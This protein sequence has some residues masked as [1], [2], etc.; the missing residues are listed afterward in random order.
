M[1]IILPASGHPIIHIHFVERAFHG[2]GEAVKIYGEMRVA[3]ME[4]VWARDLLMKSIEVL[5]LTPLT[6]RHEGF[7]AQNYIF[8]KGA[9][10][11]YASIDVY[12]DAG[13]QLI[14]GSAHCP[15][16]GMGSIWLNFL[17]MGD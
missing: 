5:L 7:M 6:T 15:A 11:N 2:R 16:D 1:K 12:D 9:F 8:D 17:A 10:N 14:P 13:N 4:Q 3:A